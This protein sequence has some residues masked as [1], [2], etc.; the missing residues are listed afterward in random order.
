M[1]RS[2][3]NGKVHNGNRKKL[4]EVLEK[5]LFPRLLFLWP[6]AGIWHGVDL[7]DTLYAMTNYRFAAGTGSTWDMATFLANRLG[8]GIL[9]LPYAG[10]FLGFKVYATLLVSALAV[11]SYHVLK[12]FM[13]GWMVFL[14][15]W[16]AVSLTWCP[17]VILYNYLTYFLLTAACLLLF[18]GVSSVPEKGWFFAAAGVCLGLNVF[19]RFSNITQAAL[20]LPVWFHTAITL[21]KSTRLLPRTL[22]CV[23]GY[24]GG[25]FAGG[26]FLA[27]EGHLPAY[28]AMIGNLFTMTGTA[29]DYSLSGMLL[30]T[31]SAYL[32]SLRWLLII[33]A[34]T[35]IGALAFS[36]PLFK[37]MHQALKWLFLAGAAL[38]LVFL[39]RRGMYTLNYR[40]YWSMFEWGM[41]FL[42]MAILLSAAGMTRVLRGSVEERFLACLT[43]VLILILPLG[44]NNY[45]F[46]VLNNL[47]IIAPITLWLFRKA[48]VVMAAAKGSEAFKLMGMAMIVMLLIQGSVFHMLYSFRDGTDGSART[49]TVY[50]FEAVGRMRTTKENAAVLSELQ[51][52]M[53]RFSIADREEKALLATGNVPGVHY[54]LNMRP[55]LSTAWPDLDSYIKSDLQRDLEE[56]EGDVLYLERKL[57]PEDPTAMSAEKQEVLSAYLTE[58]GYQTV[59]D[60]TYWKIM[61]CAQ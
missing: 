37:K 26:L 31:G 23:G 21:Q 30:S 55:S 61:T 10:T 24:L 32:H 27:L 52:G 54:L 60:G 39:Q 59:F 13:P 6:F 9:H 5:E 57:D 14:G 56:Q 58:E 4:Q 48:V 22:Q 45:T 53:S 1:E 36:L 11:I 19:V 8:Q 15:E 44:S 2:Y 46:P 34:C 43:L 12:R 49:E 16:I 25:I 28:A 51:E 50:S 35:S 17:T 47:F 7:G 42:I 33:F 38:L 41:L 40:D 29:S 20:I 3:V 18:L